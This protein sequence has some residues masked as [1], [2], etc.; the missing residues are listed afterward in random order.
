MQVS[1]PTHIQYLGYFQLFIGSVFIFLGYGLVLDP[2]FGILQFT[3]RLCLKNT[4]NH[5]YYR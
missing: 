3:E 2:C 4:D 5:G 1:I